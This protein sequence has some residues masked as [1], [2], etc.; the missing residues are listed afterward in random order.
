MRIDDAA[1]LRAPGEDPED[2]RTPLLLVLHGYG[3]NEHDLLP[4]LPHLAHPGE[5][6]VLRAPL[7]L[8]P[9]QWAWFPLTFAGPLLGA[10]RGDLEEAAQAVLAWLDEHAD[11]RTAVALGFSQ[12]AAVALQALRAD[13]DRFAGVVALSGF[14]GVGHPDDAAADERLAGE[15][16]PVFF[17]HGTADPVI[18][19]AATAATSE[20]LATHASL[21][22]RTYVGLPHAVGGEEIA[23]VRAFLRTLL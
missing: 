3:A 11:G 8:G 21:T 2:T 9:N 13:P 6:A 22:E 4:L 19:A 23:D 12:G 14:V 18:P 16:V 7:A 1:T 5:T 15:G 20:W 10:E 17:G